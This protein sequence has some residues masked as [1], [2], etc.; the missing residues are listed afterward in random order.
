M[1]KLFIILFSFGFLCNSF[2][3]AKGGGE[4]SSSSQADNAQ[5]DATT[6]TSNANISVLKELDFT[7][8]QDFEDAQRGLIAAIPDLDI[9]DATGRS[10]WNMKDYAFL[11]N[12]TAPATVNPSLWRQSRLNM[13]YGLFKVTDNIYQIRG[14]DLSNMTIIEGKTGLI[15]I[16]PLV[17][18]ETAKAGLDLYFYQI[19]QKTGSSS[20]LYP[21]TC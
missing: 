12:E 16:D 8:K 5:K 1:K 17:S 9:K 19:S 10:I 14:F 13:N 7:S 21:F 2:L 3:F 6:A 20:Y 18:P 11:N 4:K 15:L